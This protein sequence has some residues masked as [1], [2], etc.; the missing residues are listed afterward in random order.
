MAWVSALKWSRQEDYN[1]QQFQDWNVF[2]KKA[3]EFKT[4]GPLT[5]LKVFDA[6]HMVRTAPHSYVPAEDC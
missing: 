5:F 2:G 6:G 3:G 1:R 4:A